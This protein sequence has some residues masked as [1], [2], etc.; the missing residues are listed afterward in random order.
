MPPAQPGGPFGQCLDAASKNTKLSVW[1][2]I[3]VTYHLITVIPR[4]GGGGGFAK[5]LIKN[6]YEP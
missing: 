5:L 4:V 1:V 6:V 2:R 3:Y